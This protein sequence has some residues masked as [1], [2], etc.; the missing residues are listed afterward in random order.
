MPPGGQSTADPH[1]RKALVIALPVAGV[2]LVVFLVGGFLT[3]RHVVGNKGPSYPSKWDPRVEALVDFV[4]TQRELEW[5]HP[6][7]IDFVDP[8]EFEQSVTVDEEL[9]DEDR[10]EVDDA[11]ASLRAMGLVEGEVDLVSQ[12]ND[13]QA[14]GVAAYYSFKT[15]RIT[16]KGTELDIATKVTLVHELTHAIQDQNFDLNRMGTFETEAENTNLRLVAEGDAHQIEQDYVAQLSDSDRGAYMEASSEAGDDAK[17][18]ISEVPDIMVALFAAPYRV[19]PAFVAALR[20]RHGNSA[21][22]A[23]LRTPPRTEAQVLDLEQYFD[24][25]EPVVVEK[26]TLSEGEESIDESDFGA[27]GWFLV[28]S[29]RIDPLTA[30]DVVD[31]WAGDSMV[32]YRTD[33]RVCVAARYSG[34]NADATA[35]AATALDQW[36]A[37]MPSGMA[38]VAR[39]GDFVELQSCDPGADAKLDL[40]GRSMDAIEYPTIR[41]QLQ[42]SLFREFLDI[43]QPVDDPLVF[44]AVGSFMHTLSFEEVT[45]QTNVDPSEMRGRMGKAVATCRN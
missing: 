16:V 4:G 13:L 26:K 42:T 1:H 8:A 20:E 18:R 34:V 45:N 15:K 2:L 12:Q 25:R 21:V 5:E 38:K 3:L 27:M 24:G 37:T 19:G 17:D 6:V 23:A 39:L 43:G 10:A 44:C 36:A 28:L 41:L 30:L 22:D 7:Y 14:G 29:E 11:T 40:D 35:A 31:G 9:S 32:T 33:G